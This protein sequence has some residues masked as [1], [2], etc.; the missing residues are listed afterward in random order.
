MV[1]GYDTVLGPEAALSG[2]KRQRLT[3]AR[4]ILAD[5]PVL[6]PDRLT[7]S[8]ENLTTTAPCAPPRLSQGCGQDVWAGAQLSAG[9]RRKTGQPISVR[10]LSEFLVSRGPTW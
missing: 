10:H 1:D 3:I 7:G 4:A 6:V 9:A 8:G 5:T 2:G